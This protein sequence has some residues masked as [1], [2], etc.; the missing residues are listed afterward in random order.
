MKKRIQCLK[1]DPEQLTGTFGQHS[2][3]GSGV[4]GSNCFERTASMR[5]SQ[6]IHSKYSF[7]IFIQRVSVHSS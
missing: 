2:V 4:V 6:F 7:K 5:S 1:K 3:N